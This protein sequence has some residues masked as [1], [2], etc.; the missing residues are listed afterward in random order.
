MPPEK[1]T[2]SALFSDLGERS[3]S[4]TSA[5]L[6]TILAELIQIERTARERAARAEKLYPPMGMLAGLAIAVLMV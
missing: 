4:E 1:N 6:K 5:K 3:R 2:L